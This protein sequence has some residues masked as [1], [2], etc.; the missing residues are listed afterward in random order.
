MPTEH[1][2]A[3]LIAERDKLNAA[4]TALQG[5]AKNP[6]AGAVPAPAAAASAPA[7]QGR[8]FTPAQRKKQAESMKAYWA[9]KRKAA[10][11]EAAKKTNKAGAKKAATKA[12][13][14]ITRVASIKTA[15][16]PV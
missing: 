1:I 13:T 5:P 3:L 2:L 11:P 8:K 14:P 10:Q 15:P 16:A 4:I 12:P 7:K 6:V 9:A